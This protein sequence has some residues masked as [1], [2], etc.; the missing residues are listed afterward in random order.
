MTW[1]EFRIR[2]HA[3]KRL[4]LKEWQKVREI[5]WNGL[6]GSHVNPKKLPRSKEAF[7]PLDH[8][9]KAAITNKMAQRIKE[10]QAEYLEQRKQIESNGKR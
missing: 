10:V 4:E 9:K 3:Y 1:A 7:I 2:L 6:I 8:K 5:A